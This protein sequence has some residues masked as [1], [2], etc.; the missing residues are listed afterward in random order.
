MIDAEPFLIPLYIF[1]TDVSGVDEQ[2]NTY[3]FV[4][5]TRGTL[6]TCFVDYLYSAWCSI[7]LP[8]E[9]TIF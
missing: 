3:L 4:L 7:S 8:R 2:L 6:Q 1:E 5:R 9:E